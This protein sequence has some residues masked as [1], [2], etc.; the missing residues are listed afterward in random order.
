MNVK[1]RTK[2][3]HKRDIM[4][5][6]VRLSLDWKLDFLRECADFLARWEE[7]KKPGLTRETFLALRHTYIAL[8]DC[9]SYLLDQ[10]GFNFVLLGHLQSDA[11]ERRFG[12]LRQMSGA[13]YYI[14]MRQVLDSDRKI[15]P[16]HC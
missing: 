6:P 13:H 11:I 7:S 3:K 1:S 12:W 4:K 5:D 8:A 9:S 14:S 10:K 16:C 2:G 15:G